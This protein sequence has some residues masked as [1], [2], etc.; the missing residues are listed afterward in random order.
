[1]ARDGIRVLGPA[2]PPAV[3]GIFEPGKEGGAGFQKDR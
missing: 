3:P 1:M 2:F